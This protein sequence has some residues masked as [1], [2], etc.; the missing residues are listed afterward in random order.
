MT[1]I[2][3]FG[4]GRVATALATQLSA[5]GHNV[6]IGTRNASGASA[7]WTGPAVTFANHSQTARKASIVINA[8]PGD[9]SLERLSALREE[10]D[11]KILVDV[12]NAT[13]RGAEGLPAGLLYPGSSLAEHLQKALPNTQVVKTLNTMF[14]SVMINPHS[15]TVPPTAFLSGNDDGAK[16]TVSK[17]LHDLGWPPAWVEDLGDISTAQGTEALVLLVPHIIRRRGFAPFALAISR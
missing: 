15:L 7:K 5:T 12:S 11:G 16:A 9:T 6:V 10:L 1:S 8:T 17:L 14:F 2:G 13:R 3:I 4:S